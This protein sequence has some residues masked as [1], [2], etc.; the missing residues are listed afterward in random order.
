MAAADLVERDRAI[1]TGCFI[2]A[3]AQGGTHEDGRVTW[4]RSMVVGPWGE[5]I[6]RLDNDAPGVLFAD[7]ELAAVDKARRA[8]PQLTHDRDFAPPT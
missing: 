6:A 3:P 8:V 2:L 1:E 4:G 7:L 5:V